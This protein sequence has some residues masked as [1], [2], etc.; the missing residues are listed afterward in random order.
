MRPSS[1]IYDLFVKFK[2][3]LLKDHPVQAI[4]ALCEFLKR[5]VEMIELLDVKN[6]YKRVQDHLDDQQ[7]EHYR[8]FIEHLNSHSFLTEDLTTFTDFSTLEAVREVLQIS[9][10]LFDFFICIFYIKI[11]YYVYKGGKYRRIIRKHEKEWMSYANIPKQQQDI[12]RK[13]W[14]K[15]LDNARA[16][17]PKISESVYF[18]IVPIALSN[19]KTRTRFCICC[20]R[21]EVFR[22]VRL[23]TCVGCNIVT[24]CS[25]ECQARDWHFHKPNCH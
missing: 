12:D 15:C 14:K 25:E 3:C 1:E 6:F 7:N 19:R 13:R 8:T 23:G 2:P 10:Q 20:G 18:G 16:I 17:Y 11:C 4:D 22:E 9:E 24:Y 5:E 21:R